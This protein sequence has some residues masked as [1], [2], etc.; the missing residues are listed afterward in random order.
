MASKEPESGNASISAQGSV[1]LS[2][3][4]V[5]TNLPWTSSKGLVPRTILPATA[6]RTTTS[7]TVADSRVGSRHTPLVNIESDI[8]S[9]NSLLEHI[10]RFGLGLRP[11]APIPGD[12][13][14]WYHSNVDLINK[15]K[16]KAPTDHIELRK[17]VVMSMK[18]HPQMPYWVRTVFH[19]KKR[20]YN[21]FLKEQSQPGAFTDHNG[22]AV[23]ATA[24]YLKVNY[25]LVGTLNTEQAPV[26]IYGRAEEDDRI[27]FHIGY[28]QEHNGGHFI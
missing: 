17:A 13:N 28:H 27:I 14:C 20:D 6:A 16:V 22:L 10:S 11:R 23:I 7:A 18:N 9:N 3:H 21:R 1:L 15:F 4:S 25:H 26:S 8:G 5:F 24:D 2:S 19:G 12:G